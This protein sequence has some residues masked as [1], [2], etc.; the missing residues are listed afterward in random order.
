MILFNTT[1]RGTIIGAILT[2]TVCIAQAE[3]WTLPKLM[4]AL[5]QNK[6]SK[7]F[8]V[9]KKFI[10]IIDKPIVSSGEL[11][12]TAPDKLEKRTLKPKPELLA[13]DGD[14]LTVDQPGKQRFT[15]S[16][17]E[18]PEI[19]VFIESIRGTLAGDRS[20]LEKFYALDLTGSE[21]DWHLVLTPKQSRLLNIITHLRISGSSAKL[22]S[23]ELEQGDGDHSQMLIT[24]LV[25][26]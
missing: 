2:L 1:C 20:T 5:A 13:L 4:Q 6:N 3:N 7:A 18:H 12:F 8:F 15:V 26:Q 17:Q 23:I 24:Y 25:A 22:R 9:E 10:G 14:N 19:A 21:V 11:A 16:L